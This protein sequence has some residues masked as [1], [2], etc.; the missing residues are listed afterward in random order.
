MLTSTQVNQYL[1]DFWLNRNQTKQRTDRTIDLR[2]N[3]SSQAP[4]G[5]GLIDKEAL[6]AYRSPT[7]PGTAVFW[8]VLTR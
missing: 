7:P 8:T 3:T 1:A 4:T 5:Q 2:A 6:A